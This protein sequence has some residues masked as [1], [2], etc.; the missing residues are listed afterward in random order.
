MAEP[1]LAPQPL[2]VSLDWDEQLLAAQIGITRQME[3]RKTGAYSSRTPER[4]GDPVLCDINAAGAEM[5]VAK[6]LGCYWIGGVNRWKQADVAPDIEVRWTDKPEGKLIV[7]TK[8]VASRRFVLVRGG[9][10]AYELVGWIG[11]EEAMKEQWWE[12]PRKDGGAY[13]VPEW[14]LERF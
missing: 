12:D 14:A 7:R 9:F 2:I 3:A 11:G 8:D 1:A 10:P 13:F 6:Y 4:R 5:A